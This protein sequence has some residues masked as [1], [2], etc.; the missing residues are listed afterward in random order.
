MRTDP[1]CIF[2]NIVAGEIPSIKVFEDA[3]TLAFMDINPANEG[4]TLA[5]PKE[6]WEDLAAIPDELLAATARTAKKVA[7]AVKASLNPHGLNLVQANG[8]GA[9]QSVM[10]FHIHVLPRTKGDELMLNWG[11]RPGEIEPI[12]RLA[13]RISDQL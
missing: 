6:H 9:A 8:R 1:E 3:D 2:C 7:A 11:L 5:I 12:K 4:H 13:Q 10:H